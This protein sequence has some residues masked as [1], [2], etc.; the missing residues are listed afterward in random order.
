[1]G[2]DENRDKYNAGPEPKNRFGFRGTFNSTLYYEDFKG[3]VA[4]FQHVLGPPVYVEGEGTRAWRI[5]EG[6]LTILKGTDGN[7]KNTELTL[8]LNTPAEAEQLQVQMIEAGAC[9][10]PPT[11]QIMFVPVRYCPVKDPFGV[12]ILVFSQL[13]TD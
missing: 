9:G 11:N 8:E 12:E 1:L 10:D 13:G 7:P 4:F 5:G 2:N 3:A 6:W